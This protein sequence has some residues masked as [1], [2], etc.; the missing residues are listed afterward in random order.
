MYGS[1]AAALLQLA[2]VLE[3]VALVALLVAALAGLRA[4][5]RQ[6]SRLAA[7]DFVR[8]T[9]ATRLAEGEPLEE[10]LPQV[11]G[12]LSHAFALD[13]AEIWQVSGDRLVLSASEPRRQAVIPR[14][15][16]FEHT[17]AGAPVA[18]TAWVGAWL[19][20]MLQAWPDGALR[21]AP[22]IQADHLVG[23]VVVARV[24]GGWRL[25]AEADTTLEELAR[26]VGHAIHKASLD[27]AL[28]ESLDRLR[29]R[30]DDLS[31]SRVRIVLAADAERR[32]IER[33]LHDG[34]QQYLVALGV[35]IRL[36]QRLLERDPRGAG[37]IGEELAD[38]IE[39]AIEALRNLARGIYPMLLSRGGL[40]PALAEACRLAGITARLQIGTLSR[41]SAEIEAA[42]YFCCVEALQ[43][44]ARH[45]GADAEARVRVWEEDDLLRFEV[46]DDGVGFAAPS[47]G[48]GAGLT[49]MSD[50]LGALGGSLEVRSAPGAGTRVGGQVPVRTSDARLQA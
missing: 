20:E 18:G 27:A 50:R 32:R 11:V 23:L 19:P 36:L 43:N 35:K 46:L 2:A 10:L 14:L 40:G 3:A 4:S 39:R 44:T 42:V 8:A 34:A 37:E 45:A 1:D 48:E 29:H 17:L 5:R 28:Q 6:A 7:I 12:A 9:F 25:A 13:A 33:N 15:P 38:D 21:V 31:A 24:R 22:V 30:T 16:P 47:A 41:Q 26:E 49:N